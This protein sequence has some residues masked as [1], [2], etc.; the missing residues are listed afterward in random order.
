MHKFQLLELQQG[1][2]GKNHIDQTWLFISKDGRLRGA[3]SI[4]RIRQN[5]CGL[6]IGD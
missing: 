5:V 6:A 1:K 4:Q 3:V 2:F